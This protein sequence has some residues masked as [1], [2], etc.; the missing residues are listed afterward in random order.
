MSKKTLYF[1]SMCGYIVSAVLEEGKLTEFNFEKRVQGTL[2]GNI[3]KGRVEAVLPG[4]Q[5]AFI[6][7]GLER[8]CYLC[9]DDVYSENAGYGEGVGSVS[10]PALKEGDEILVQVNKLPVG[11]KGAKVTVHPSF[12]GKNLIYTPNTPFIGVSRKFDDGELRDN[13]IYSVKKLLKDGEGLIVRTSAPYATRDRLKKEYDFLKKIYDEV[14]EKFKS[15]KTGDLL[16]TDSAL[17]VRVLRDMLS[18][19][20]DRI[21]VGSEKLKELIENMVD[22]APSRN[23]GKLKVHNTGRVMFE[24]AGISAQ[25]ADIISPRIR[26]EN[27]AEIVIERTEALTVVDVNTGKFT[28]DDSLEQTVYFTNVLA[29]REIARQVKL[30]NIGGIIVVD[31]IDMQHEAH[32]KAVVSEL[33]LALKGDKAKCVVS[34]MS[35]FG[36]VEFTRKRIGNDPMPV[37]VK[38]CS[39]CNGSG[40]MLTEEY[41]LLNLRSKIFKLLSDGV[42]SLLVEMNRKVFETMTVWREYTDDLKTRAGDVKIYFVPHRTY[43]EEQFSFGIDKFDVP[44]DATLL[45]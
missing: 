10:F 17:P 25:L 29:A 41:I 7:C 44:D 18:D 16:Y 40:F 45:N 1:D 43:H 22:Y 27:G 12:I 39:Y 26:L 33:E 14:R 8:N 38:P 19:D 11:K 35:R 23:R 3:Y 15:A 9:T 21:V 13:L 2:I 36:L 6:N 5:A 34:P 24:E 32:K 37:F 4:M 42:K 31:F 30:R 20:V 28:G